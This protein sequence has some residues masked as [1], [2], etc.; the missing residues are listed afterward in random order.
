M[1]MNSV[2]E[3]IEKVVSSSQ[4]P[5]RRRRLEIARDLRAHIEDFVLIARQA[6]HSEEEIRRL[7]LANFGDPQEIA[8]EFA[9]VYRYERAILRVSVFLLS[10]LVAA[11]FISVAV[12]AL[13]ASM[14]IGLGVPIPHV[15]RSRHLTFETLYLLSTATAY[16]GL[17]SLEKLFDSARLGK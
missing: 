9:R 2:D 8:Q 15:F 13:Q 7:V 5:S 4:I 3:L 1:N 14:A 17:I 16:V 6:G 12:L 11:S 10:T